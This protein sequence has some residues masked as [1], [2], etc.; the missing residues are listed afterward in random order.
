MRAALDQEFHPD[1]VGRDVVDRWVASFED[2]PGTSGL[3]DDH[4]V[5]DD[6]DEFGRILD[7]WRPWIVPYRFLTGSWLDFR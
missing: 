3:G 6:T 7:T 5:E 2:T 1:V 4:T